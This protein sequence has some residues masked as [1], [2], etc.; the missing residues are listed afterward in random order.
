[1][2]ASGK[3]KKKLSPEKYFRMI[4]ICTAMF[5]AMILTVVIL[6]L[7]VTS[8]SVVSSVKLILGLLAIIFCIMMLVVAIRGPS[9]EF[10]KSCWN[11]GA[12]AAFMTI[13]ALILIMPLVVASIDGFIDGVTGAQPAVSST[14][15][16]QQ[17]MPSSRWGIGAEPSAIVS[18]AVFFIT[19]QWRRFR[20]VI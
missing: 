18:I 20:G 17:E 9:D 15:T 1:M 6:S 12:S 14:G 10:A 5:F 3:T 7:A 19:F 11:G 13:I 8:P 4:D 16:T 2:S